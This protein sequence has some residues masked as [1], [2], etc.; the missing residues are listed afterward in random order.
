MSRTYRRAALVCGLALGIAVAIAL[1]P[2][3]RGWFD[4]GVYHGAVN[5]WVHDG[6]QLYDYLRP[7]TR[8]GFTYPPFAAV[9]MLPMALLGWYPT[10]AANL[11]LTALAA[12]FLLWLL[13]DPLAARL[14][15]PRW[16]T[17]GI[18]VCLFAALNPVRD[19]VSFGQ[20]NLLL[21]ALVYLDLWLLERGSRLAGI[22]IGLAAAIK[23]TPAV[24]VGY[25]LLTRRWR[26]AVTAVGCAVA[27]TL[28]AATVAP[29]A[30]LTYFAEAMWDTGRI[31]VLGYISNQSLSGLVARWDPPGPDGPTWLLLV[32]V[33]LAAWA[34]RA[35][36]AGQLGDDRAGFALTGL[37]GCLVSPI[38]WV[39]H[40]VWAVPA[41][42]ALAAVTLPWP[43]AGAARRRFR[44]GVGAY[45]VLV[46]GLVWLW[47][48]DHRG[49]LGFVGGSSYVL[50]TLGLLA[51]LPI[52]PGRPAV[53][54]TLP[55]RTAVPAEVP[56]RTAVPAEVPDRTAAPATVPDRA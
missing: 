41:L 38:T 20:I 48:V 7:G 55:E 26:A 40:L 28:L 1:L 23:L 16:F 14:P 31:G 21:V 27:S 12:G 25:L 37:A 6:G 3:H 29:A 32:G 22:G 17:F 46:S 45:L 10:I 44:F 56:D 54:T 9:C 4:V 19:T 47:S 51:L 15:V 33:V 8:Y 35:R 34:W 18:A 49:V 5:Y 53:P 30:S 43:P 24:F 50:V 2:G 36:W 13:V 42:V 52:R 11:L 39:H